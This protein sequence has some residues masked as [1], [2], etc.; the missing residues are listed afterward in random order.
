M[1]TNLIETEEQFSL[2]II[3]KLRDSFWLSVGSP[4]SPHVRPR[5]GGSRGAKN[6]SQF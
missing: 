6:L 4:I 3:Q 5:G 1:S 2:G